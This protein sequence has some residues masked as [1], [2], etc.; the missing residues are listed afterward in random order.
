MVIGADHVGLKLK[1]QLKKYLIKK[2]IAYEDA[3]AYSLDKDDDYP[4]YAEKVAKKVSK[5]NDFGIL[6]CGSGTG[7]A[8]AANKI[9]GIRAA[10]GYSLDEVILA[11]KHNAINVLCLN[12]IDYKGIAKKLKTGKTLLDIK[13]KSANFNEI[14]KMID[15]FLNTDFEGGR[16]ERR[17]LK[18]ARLE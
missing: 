9:K 17:L 18:I 8:I 14:I 1:E 15:A 16:H 5:E 6:L 4:D 3:G 11:R 10:V 12:S 2:K 7:M 13:A